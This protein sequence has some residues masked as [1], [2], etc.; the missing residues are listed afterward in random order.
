M[1]RRRTWLVI[2]LLVLLLGGLSWLL[3]SRDSH[4][5]HAHEARGK[6]ITDTGIQ[7]PSR[8]KLWR[9]LS[10]ADYNTRVVFAGVTVLGAASGLVGTFL[11]LRKRSLLSDT[12]SHCTLPGIA[13]AFL[14]AEATGIS[15][16]S[17]PLLLI[18]AAVTGVL[19]MGAVAAIRAKSRIKDDAALAIVL[20]VFFGFGIALMVIIQQLPT[21][22]A[23]GLSHF[24][25]GKAASM[26]AGD[27]QLILFA[28][29]AV[30]LVCVVLFKEFKLLCF[31]A[32]FAR[33]QGWPTVALDLALMGLV[34]A[35]TVI[36]LQAVG[37]LLVVALLIIPAAAAR[38]WSHRLGVTMLLATLIGAASGLVGVAASALF[39]KLPAGAV[40]V[41]AAVFCFVV[42]FVFGAERGLFKRWLEQ[43][44]V[45]QRVAR[46]HLLRA[47]YEWCETK[48]QANRDLIS[49]LDCA[50]S[51]A[52]LRRVNDWSEGR[53]QRLLRI[54]FTERLIIWNN[55]HDAVHLTAEGKLEAR[56]VTRNHRLWETYLL[57]YADVA[58]QHIHHNA[59]QIEH[60]IEPNIVNELEELL[61]GR[62]GGALVPADPEKPQI[63]P[64][65]LSA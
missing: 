43:R 3:R 5:G 54:G 52:E 13:I 7:W 21:G 11:L 20:S 39:P 2:G 23:A 53:L 12:V 42:S 59:D 26:T 48:S 36:G 60:V 14:I 31:D 56:R 25:Y 63:V 16:R 38:F 15:G 49:L 18:G 45:G 57:Q 4:I 6:S 51:L 62:E 64:G 9:T 1:N 17:L 32:S 50:V 40:I 22:N 27:A 28:S 41:L 24:I 33:T 46:Q 58:P 29:L 37:L 8:E 19:G 65:G 10:L 30:A 44:R 35:V 34:V 55:S 47:I 61:A